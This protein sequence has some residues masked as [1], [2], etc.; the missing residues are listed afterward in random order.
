MSPKCSKRPL[1]AGWLAQLVARGGGGGTL[2]I[3]GSGCAP[4]TLEPSAYTR[5]RSSE[6]CYPL[7]DK[8]PKI[9]LPPTPSQSSC[10]PE[11]TE[12]TNTVQPKQNRFDFFIFL[13]GNS[14]F[15]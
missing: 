9:P 6:F 10:F 15:P 3:F 7:L 14:R 13:S 2:G 11:T 5:A 1:T 8:T 4:G 12:V